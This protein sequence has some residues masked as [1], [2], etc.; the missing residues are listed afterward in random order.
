MRAQ[1]IQALRDNA[2]RM[3]HEAQL[4]SNATGQ[5]MTEEQ[6]AVIAQI[7]TL[8]ALQENGVNDLDKSL[9]NLRAELAALQPTGGG[10]DWT[11]LAELIATPG[12]LDGSVMPSCV[13][14]CWSTSRK[15]DMS[16]TLE[17]SRSSSARADVRPSIKAL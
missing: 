9:E 7:A 6:S 8:E 3:A 17:R 11:G 1:L 15:F 2:D 13:R 4:A 14:C 12:V 16:G 5:Q 10:P